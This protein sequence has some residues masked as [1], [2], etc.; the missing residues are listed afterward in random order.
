[1]SKELTRRAFGRVLGA[2]ALAGALPEIAGAMPSS[3]PT[4]S[5]ASPETGAFGARR[6]TL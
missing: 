4:K 6:P 2:A 3:E 1:M 5:A